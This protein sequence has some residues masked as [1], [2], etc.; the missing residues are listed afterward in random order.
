MPDQ[1]PE[2]ARPRRRFDEAA[3]APAPAVRR[4]I[5]AA[6]AGI[7]LAAGLTIFLSVY[8]AKSVTSVPP[9]SVPVAADS[10][11]VPQPAPV[12]ATL[13]R[14]EAGN[15][16]LE[17]LREAEPAGN[18][19][20]EGCVTAKAPQAYASRRYA[21]PP[22]EPAQGFPTFAGQVPGGDAP[23]M[24]SEPA[25]PPGVVRRHDPAQFKEMCDRLY[26]YKVTN[27]T[28][29]DWN[30]IT[31]RADS[32]ESWTADRLGAGATMDVKTSQPTGSFDITGAQ[33][34]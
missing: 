15:S 10:R 5:G 20:C 19:N 13:P 30:N 17:P 25:I 24:P 8:S 14:V 2:Q 11:P 22:P 18:T 26:L 6:S 12:P 23:V 4:S 27:Q 1:Q 28:G 34:P 3:G 32:G 29:K 31:I 16:A 21:Q 33:A 9:A 7:V